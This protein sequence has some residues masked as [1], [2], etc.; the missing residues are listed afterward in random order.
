MSYY[1]VKSTA[2]TLYPQIGLRPMRDIDLLLA[3]EDVHHAHELLKKQGF[4]ADYTPMP[5]DHFHLQPLYAT[6]NGLPLYCDPWS[7][8]NISSA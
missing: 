2:L 1:I 6:A 8:L 5:F 3:K 4:A 7:V